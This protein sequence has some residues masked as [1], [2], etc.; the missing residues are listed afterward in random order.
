MHISYCVLL[1]YWR[2]IVL[3]LYRW[4][5]RL[6]MV[7]SQMIRHRALIGWESDPEIS[8]PDYSYCILER[9][10]R[11]RWQGELQRDLHSGAFKWGYLTLKEIEFISC[12][13]YLSSKNGILC[14][15][16]DARKMHYHRRVLDRNRLITLQSHVIRQPNGN[17]QYSILLLLKRFHV[18]R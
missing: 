15:R 1:I 6:V 9:L 3:I 7:A 5:E 14:C 16:I 10:G 11:A 2:L 17:Q 8:L 18:D 12:N 4:G 13:L